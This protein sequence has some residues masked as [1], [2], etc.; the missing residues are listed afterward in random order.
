MYYLFWKFCELLFF[1][2]QE[3]PFTQSEIENEV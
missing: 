1:F 3:N 2:P